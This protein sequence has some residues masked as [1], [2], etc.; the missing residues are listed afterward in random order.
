MA[1]VDNARYYKIEWSGDLTDAPPTVKNY[2]T[3][4]F[5][6]ITIAVSYRKR[7]GQWCPFKAAITGPVLKSDSTDGKNNV[8]SDYYLDFGA[9]DAPAWVVDIAT[10]HTP[11]VVR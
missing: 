4:T 2:G 10:R 5:R 8:S 7:D 9:L 3:A 11:T 1:T 6:P